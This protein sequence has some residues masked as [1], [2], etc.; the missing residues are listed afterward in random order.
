[1]EVLGEWGIRHLEIRGLK[2]DPVSEVRSSTIKSAAAKIAKAG[3]S[4]SAIASC[5]GKYRIDEPFEIHRNKLARVQDAAEILG[6]RLIRV[7]SFYPDAWGN[8][9]NRREEVIERI[10]AMVEMAKERNQVLLLENAPRVYGESPERCR[11]ILDA[12]HSPHLCVSFDFGNYVEAGVKPF[13]RAYPMLADYI[14]YVQIK[15]AT[16]EITGQCR[17]VL[18]GQGDGQ[19]Y[20]VLSAL[21]AEKQQLY[22]SIEPR[23]GRLEPTVQ[24]GAQASDL[25]GQAVNAVRSI[26]QRIKAST[27][28]ERVPQMLP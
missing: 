8:L 17:I 22:L 14:E 20:E 11:D 5:I 15:D 21:L 13:T 16:K 25:C 3:F 19:V 9:L 23:G 28:V 12:I 2:G 26:L 4:V 6:T 1:M 7:F 10:A 24:N 18:A 27:R